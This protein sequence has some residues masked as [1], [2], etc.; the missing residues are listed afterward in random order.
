MHGANAMDDLD[1]EDLEVPDFQSQLFDSL[2]DLQQ[3][4]YLCDTNIKVS[5]F[6]SLSLYL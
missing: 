3:D 6:P 5:V 1:S 2:F 4:D